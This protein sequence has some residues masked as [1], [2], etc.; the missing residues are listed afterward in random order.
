M[1]ETIIIALISLLGTL[2]GSAVFGG[3]PSN[4]R[5]YVHRSDLAWFETA[6]NWSLFYSEGDIVAAADYIEYLQSIGVDT[7]DF[8]GE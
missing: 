1:S 8:E 2:G 3:N 5:F 4:Q 7:S 6:T